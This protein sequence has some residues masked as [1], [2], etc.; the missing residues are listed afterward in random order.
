MKIIIKLSAVLIMASLLFTTCA[1]RIN[2][3]CRIVASSLNPFEDTTRIY[4]GSNG[5]V[6]KVVNSFCVTEYAYS[7]NKVTL[8][9]KDTGKFIAKTIVDLNNKGL[10]TNVKVYFDEAGTGWVNTA[11]EYDGE[12]VQKE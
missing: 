9:R 7:G 11:Y 4:Y 1:K 6:Q 3:N 10:A 2:T 5:K 8:I 12:E